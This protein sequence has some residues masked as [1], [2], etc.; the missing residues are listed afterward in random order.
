MLPASPTAG[1]SVAEALG[2]VD[3][4]PARS[5]DRIK[6]ELDLA[7][8]AEHQIDA[9]IIETNS[10]RAQT[11]ALLE[12]KKQEVSSLDSRIK[13]AG[14]QKQD[15]DKAALTAEKTVVER[16][17]AF[18]ERREALYAAEQEQAKAA[19]KFAL[20]SQ[21]ALQME[22]Q[23]AARRDERARSAGDPTAL[24]RHDS[25]IR[26]LELRTLQAQQARAEAAK[27]VASR[28]QE[29]ARR[30]LELY[31]AQAAASGQ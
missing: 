29:N 10:Q 9:R 31:Q 28:D 12:G 18:L 30:R 3:V 7:I 6:G 2:F 27:D 14:K 11:K 19:K 13:L 24:L 1:K 20:A 15:A 16:Q 23:L 26:E 4:I 22:L 8:A 5:A 25:V 17:R 21:Q